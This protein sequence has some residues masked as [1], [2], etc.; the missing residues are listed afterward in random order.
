MY[1]RPDVVA[2]ARPQ[3]AARGLADRCELVG[4]DFLESV[5][6]GGDLYLIAR[7]L[8]NWSD[9]H[10]LRIL[11]HTAEAT[12]PGDRVLVIERVILPDTNPKLVLA[13]DALMLL[14]TGGGRARTRDEH[15]EL[16][17]KSGFALESVLPLPQD[18]SILVA[19]RR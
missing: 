6:G 16:L 13:Q 1:D 14:I 2:A 3:V 17:E 4:G 15:R 10:C 9:E 5:P 11:G 12:K 19:V 8:H 7:T 18:V